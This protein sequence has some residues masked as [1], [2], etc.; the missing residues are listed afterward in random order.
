MDNNVESKAKTDYHALNMNNITKLVRHPYI[1]HLYIK[2]SISQ[3]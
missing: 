3:I 2:K 1:T